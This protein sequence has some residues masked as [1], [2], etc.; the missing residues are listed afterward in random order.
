M[1]LKLLAG[2]LLAAGAACAPAGAALVVD[3]GTIGQAVIV[4]TSGNVIA[5]YVGADALGVSELYLEGRDGLIFANGGF[6]SEGEMVD[7]GYFEA[8]TELVFKLHT[9]FNEDHDYYSGLA[10]RNF[11]GFAH[12]AAS[13][14]G[15]VTFVGF[16]DLSSEDGGGDFDDLV[17]SFSN[18]RAGAPAVPEPASWA[19]MIGGLAIVGAA[20]RR[21]GAVRIQFA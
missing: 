8:G 21:K 6:S 4:A 5:T 11:D 2:A 9:T 10:S 1:N 19:L 7:L 3:D 12:A 14:D 16:E 15:D 20:M 13:T 18:T 17:F